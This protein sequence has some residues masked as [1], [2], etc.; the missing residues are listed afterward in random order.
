MEEVIVEEEMP[1]PPPPPTAHPDPIDEP[2]PGGPG[3]PGPI[4]TFPPD[5]PDYGPLPPT[6]EQR[7]AAL[8]RDNPLALLDIPCGEIPKWQAVAGEEVPQSVLD[9]LNN[10]PA[11]QDQGLFDDAAFI[12]RLEDAAGTTINQDYFSVHVDESNL[13]GGMSPEAY[14]E[15][16]RTN[17]ND[18]IDTSISEFEGYRGMTGEW[19]RWTSAN[20]L[21]SVLSID[22]FPGGL[23]YGSVVSIVNESDR[24]VF[25]TAYTPVDDYHPVS[26]NREFGF[27]RSG[28]QI[29]FY[30]RGVDRLST[31]YHSVGS[32]GQGLNP[33][34]DT[35]F[36]KADALWTSLM[37]GIKNDLQQANGGQDV[38]TVP[39]ET[40]YR[41][42]WDEVAKLYDD[43]PNNDAAV[44]SSLGCN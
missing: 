43:D 23:E 34:G 7:L 20:P 1:P 15:Q 9:R 5:D 41:P 35:A 11:L 24:W 32:W 17:L 6:A 16:I 10:E 25:G 3:D 8:L 29:T 2:L 28:S 26:G 12:Q 42:D 13:P 14:L 30:T 4:P 36:Q 31:T 38:A 18:Y 33:F 27:T 39:E 40:T 44:L 21:G 37:E 19:I 22:L